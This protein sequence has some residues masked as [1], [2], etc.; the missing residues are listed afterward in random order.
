MDGAPGLG[1]LRHDAP[2]RLG[3]FRLG[4]H[5]DDAGDA[6]IAPY[7]EEWFKAIG[8]KL[9]LQAQS[10]TALNDNLA[11]GDWDLLMDGWGG[12]KVPHRGNVMLAP[13]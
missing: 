7:L 8:I 3:E 13:D 10:M 12:Q 11:K 1:S 9:N 2:R 5:S 4:I 6:S